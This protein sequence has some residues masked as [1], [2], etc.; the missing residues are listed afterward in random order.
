MVSGEMDTSPRDADKHR[1]H[2]VLSHDS[3]QLAQH[4]VVSGTENC[5]SSN[6]LCTFTIGIHDIRE[7][8]V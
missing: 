5:P 1:G 2:S 7:K 6:I 8:C 4:R 3:L